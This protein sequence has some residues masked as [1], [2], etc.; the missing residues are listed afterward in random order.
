MRDLAASP[1]IPCVTHDLEQAH[2]LGGQVI[3]MCD[4]R[5]IETAAAMD[6]FRRPQRLESRES[7]RWSSCDCN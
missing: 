7:L 6:F 3:F 2:R 1:P 5:I 4:G